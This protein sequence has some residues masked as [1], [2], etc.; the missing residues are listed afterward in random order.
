MA[1]NEKAYA[2]LVKKIEKK[3]QKQQAKCEKTGKPFVP[4][5]IPEMDE[6]A[7]IENKKA[8]IAEMIILLLLI[9]LVVYF[10]IMW[11]SYVP[12]TEVVQV[13]NDVQTTAAAEVNYDYEEYSNPHE[14]TTA[15]DYSLADAKRFLQQII[16]DNW[17]EI[18]YS[19]DVSSSSITYANSIETVNSAECYIFSCS[20]VTYAVPLN[21]SACYYVENGEYVPLT[22]NDTDI[23]F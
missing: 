9:W 13:G 7:V 16:H 22:F 23:L 12:P 10:I 1:A 5:P 19:S 11:L 4:Q 3:N 21:L 15:A 2:A 18:G 20:G 6:V 14:I 8:K 17:K